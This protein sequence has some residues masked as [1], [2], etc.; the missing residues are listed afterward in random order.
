MEKDLIAEILIPCL[1]IVF[2]GIC[3][4]CAWLGNKMENDTD[5]PAQ[6]PNNHRSRAGTSSGDFMFYPAA[7]SLP[8]ISDSGNQGRH[9]GHHVGY[10][11]PRS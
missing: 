5:G 6:K 7:A 3:F 9:H 11:Q 10:H 4:L 2:L 8:T 1:F